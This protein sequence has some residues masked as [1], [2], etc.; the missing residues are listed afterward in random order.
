MVMPRTAAEAGARIKMLRERAG[1][2][3]TKLAEISGIGQ[4]V[5]SNWE[6]GYNYPPYE[7]VC[8]ICAALKCDVYEMLGL[9]RIDLPESDTRWLYKL[10]QLDDDGLHTIEAVLDSQLR[11]LG[12]L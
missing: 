3:Q 2:S 6:C 7:G 4:N 12:R 10:R 9:P 8:A 1:L 5:I 11:R